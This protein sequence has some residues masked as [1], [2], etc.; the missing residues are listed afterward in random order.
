MKFQ[1]QIYRTVLH[2]IFVLCWNKPCIPPFFLS[3]CRY[4]TKATRHQYHLALD[5]RTSI[6]DNLKWNKCFHR[7]HHFDA[8]IQQSYGKATVAVMCIMGLYFCLVPNICA[9]KYSLLPISAYFLTPLS[10]ALDKAQQE[11]GWKRAA[12]LSPIE[13]KKNPWDIWSCI[14]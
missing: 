7:K 2:L 8:S 13:M 9:L 11:R 12:I 10:T 5:G 6:W 1:H 3:Q 4:L 14:K